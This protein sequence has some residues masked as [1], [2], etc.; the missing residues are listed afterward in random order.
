MHYTPIITSKAFLEMADAKLWY[1]ERSSDAGNKFLGELNKSVFVIT[2]YPKRYRLIST[3]VRRYNL[4]IFPYSIFYQIRG[5][6]IL[7]L[8][9]RHYKQKRLRK[10]K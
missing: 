9:I 3:N 5:D 10:Y 1:D 8:R 6:L 4:K 7:I 2:Q